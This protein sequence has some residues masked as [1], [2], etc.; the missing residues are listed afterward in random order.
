MFTGTDA[1]PE[2]IIKKE[3]I[4]RSLDPILK[5]FQSISGGRLVRQ[6]RKIEFLKDDESSRLPTTNLSAGL[7]VFLMLQE[8]ISNGSLREQGTVVLDEPEIH[9][10]PQWQ[11]R[12]AELVVQLQKTFGLHI[13]ITTHSPYIVSALDIFSKK[14][15]VIKNNR[16]Y[17]ADRQPDG[18]Y[19][20]DVTKHLYVI[21]D[22]LAQPYQ[23]I[24]DEAMRL[25]NAHT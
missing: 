23:I 19:L 3:I 25:K 10:H 20:K 21:Y 2:A 1:T 7:K 9:L 18:C 13:L 6:G 22:S 11:V 24:E 5:Q 14:Y 17:F 4:R 16:Y 8:L 15:G 12:L